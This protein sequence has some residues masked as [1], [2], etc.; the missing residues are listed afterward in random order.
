M[1]TSEYSGY[2][3]VRS[4]EDGLQ[5]T[6]KSMTAKH[7]WPRATKL[8]GLSTYLRYAL[9]EEQPRRPFA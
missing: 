4:L 1:Y 3:G 5:G 6:S 9:I 7:V 2:R 8:V